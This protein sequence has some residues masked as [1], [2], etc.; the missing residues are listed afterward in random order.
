MT[1]VAAIL[2]SMMFCATPCALA[3]ADMDGP[4][5]L[6]ATQMDNVTAGQVGT[7]VAAASA[8][9]DAQGQFTLVG[10]Q[11]VSSVTAVQPAGQPPSQVIYVTLNSASAN[12]AA[13]GADSQTSTSI[14]GV[15]QQPVPS[16][17]VFGTTVQNTKTVLGATIAFKTQIQMGGNPIYFLL[18]PGARFGGY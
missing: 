10:T 4:L 17:S 3:Q 9:A 14:T 8:L 6:S 16:D 13:Q 11:A 5:V 7:P 15:N 12:A 2:S 18:N 1:K